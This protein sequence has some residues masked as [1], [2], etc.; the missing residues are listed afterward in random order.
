MAG[1][2]LGVTAGQVALVLG[3]RDAFLSRTA[4]HLGTDVT[5]EQAD[6]RRWVT[7]EP[8]SARGEDEVA[9]AD[10]QAAVQAELAL[11]AAE[12]QAEQQA[13]SRAARAAAREQERSAR[14]AEAAGRTGEPGESR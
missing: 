10:L 14:A 1:S 5:Q 8:R 9:A 11:E 3:E 13:E 7:E 2:L 12:R 6:R 4:H